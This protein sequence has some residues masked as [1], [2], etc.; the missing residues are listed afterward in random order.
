MHKVVSNSLGAAKCCIPILPIAVNAGSQRRSRRVRYLVAGV[1][2]APTY[3]L[4]MLNHA[5]SRLMMTAELRSGICT[6]R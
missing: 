5:P 6:T 3:G 4:R 1:L 2:S